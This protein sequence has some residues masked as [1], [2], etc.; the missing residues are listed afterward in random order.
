MSSNHEDAARIE[1][2]LKIQQGANPDPENLEPHYEKVCDVKYGEWVEV[3]W[4]GDLEG[5]IDR[6]YVLGWPTCYDTDANMGG[7]VHIPHPQNPGGKG[8]V[9][10]E[11]ITLHELRTNPEVKCVRLLE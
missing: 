8:D 9:E 1:F 10:D 2:Y 4:Q 7:V 5:T 11:W 6:G 3:V